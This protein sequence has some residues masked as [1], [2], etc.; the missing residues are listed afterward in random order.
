[1]FY[2]NLMFFNYM[3]YRRLQMGVINRFLGHFKKKQTQTLKQV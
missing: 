3:I 2:V 1:M